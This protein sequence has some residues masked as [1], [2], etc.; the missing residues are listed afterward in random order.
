MKSGKTSTKLWALILTVIGL[1]L[2]GTDWRL[3]RVEAEQALVTSEDP[4]LETLRLLQADSQS[5]LRVS[6]KHGFPRSLTA[7]VHTEGSDAVER[8]KFF[9]RRY[10]GL[11]AQNSPELELKVR[12]VSDAPGEDVLFYQTYRGIEVFGAALLISLNHDQVF[13][14]GGA[15]LTT[16][17]RL[18]PRPKINEKEAEALARRQLE[19]LEARLA[20]PTKLM[21]FDRSLLDSGATPEPHLAWRVAVGPAADT[22]QVF[23][24]AHT[25]RVL[26]TLT[27]TRDHFGPL[28]GLDL[29]MQDAEDDANAEDD[30]CFWTSDEV[31]V[32]DD[33]DFNSDYNN[34]PD[35]VQGFKH[36]QGI[37]RFFH[38]TFNRHSYDDESSQ[39]ELFIH[40]KIKTTGSWTDGCELIQIQTG[41][42]SFDVLGHEF[43]HGVIGDTS[44]L[45]YALQSGAL[46]ESYP[47][48]IGVIADQ[49]REAAQGLSTDWLIGEDKTD[50]S[51]AI[52]DLSDPPPSQPDH[53][54]DLI[55]PDED[56]D[57]EDP[58]PC[59][60][61]FNILSGDCNDHG[62]VH[63][64]SGISNKTA[65]LM[66][67]GGTHPKSGLFVFGMGRNKMRDLKWYA[68]THL[69]PFA[70]FEFAA[71]YEFAIADNWA[72]NGTSGFNAF[73]VCTVK[74]A[75][76]A[77]GL[78]QPDSDC[79]GIDNTS[80]PDPDG[81]FI[82]TGPDNCFLI[83]NPSQLNTDHDAFGDVCDDDDDNDGVLDVDDNCPI[84]FNPP[85]P[86]TGEQPSC[87]D[88]DDDGVDDSRDNCVGDFNPF[89]D[90]SDDDGEGDVCDVDSDTDGIS[91]DIDNCPLVD[92]ANQANADGDA[93]GDACDR[94]PNTKEIAK[95]GFNGMP[96]QPDSDDDG[97]PDACDHSFLFGGRTLS[98][99]GLQPEGGFREAD[100]EANP[101]TVQ[102]VPLVICERDCPEWFA[103]H[104]RVQLRF[105]GLDETTR[106]RVTDED[107][108]SVKKSTG[109][110]RHRRIDFK[111]IAGH[112]Y[113][114][115]FTFRPG[116][117][118]LER[119][120]FR[121]KVSSKHF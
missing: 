91:N 108:T 68:A 8:A 31:T 10:R 49:E 77:V 105:N 3:N 95:F 33:D 35:A 94:C 4:Q 48:I 60:P 117:L 41:K 96:F 97:I 29:D 12:H 65:F 121:M 54:L 45:I 5:Q 58:P 70:D 43:T 119:D 19:R 81:D 120:T 44:Q 36:I 114:L 104:D 6:F 99:G 28:F 18:E 82:P 74:N 75:W 2:I 71:A 88:L 11:F 85:I 61:Q 76:A 90:D 16:G 1:A 47:D 27:S 100:V 106:V 80:D 22:N 37:Y 79:D 14:A 115:T 83:P 87:N 23:V 34:D 59:P 107:G 102:H 66:A 21:V 62:W 50:G 39:I 55:A 118:R 73:D 110:T 17:T 78:G 93:F 7:R 109:S 116:A 30:N 9:L 51:G 113:F 40:A 53:I 32:A 42:V 101:G 103:H 89:Q 64:N 84:V 38:E 26:L 52:R 86:G 15:L 72:Q 24:D 98:G 69:L 46:N 63:L 56:P 20:A 57:G 67:D 92:N 112:T 25:G 111:P 13:H